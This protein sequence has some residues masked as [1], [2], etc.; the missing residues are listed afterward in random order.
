MVGYKV[1]VRNSSENWIEFQNRITE[2]FLIHAGAT[3][4]VKVKKINI[5]KRIA[6]RIWK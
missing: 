4:E 3:I 5:F 1:L 6:K 2:E